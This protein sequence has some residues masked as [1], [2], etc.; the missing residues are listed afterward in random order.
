MKGLGKFEYMSDSYF[1]LQVMKI[2]LLFLY[3]LP[4]GK[5]FVQPQKWGEIGELAHGGVLM[6][7]RNNISSIPADTFASMPTLQVVNDFICEAHWLL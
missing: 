5:V 2:V 4:M 1:F 3:I 6:I 7:E